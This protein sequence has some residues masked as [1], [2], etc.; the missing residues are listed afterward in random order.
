MIWG[1]LGPLMY[2]YSTVSYN[3]TMDHLKFWP[4]ITAVK[5][6]ELKVIIVLGKRR[7]TDFCLKQLSITGIVGVW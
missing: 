6:A 7:W 4:T 5:T 2:G 3:Q 1:F